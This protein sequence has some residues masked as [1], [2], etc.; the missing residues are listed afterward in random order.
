M[1]KLVGHMTPLP[2]RWFG[3]NSISILVFTKSSMKSLSPNTDKSVVSIEL[4]AIIDNI[5]S[6]VKSQHK[7]KM[8]TTNSSAV[9]IILDSINKCFLFFANLLSP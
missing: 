5:S 1:R 4:S 2:I 3:G 6:A 8:E 7:N 9:Y